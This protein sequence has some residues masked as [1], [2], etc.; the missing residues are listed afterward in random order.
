M[1]ILYGVMGYGR[2]HATRTAAVLPALAADHE[3]K[4]V[5]GVDAYEY[6]NPLF[7]DVEQIPTIGYAYGSEGRISVANTL[8]RNARPMTDL[9]LAKGAGSRRLDEI[10]R[11][12]QPD[13]IISDSE[14][15]THRAAKRWGIPRISF[16]HVGIMAY[17]RP[18]LPAADWWLGHRDALG[19]RLLMGWPDRVLVSSFYPALPHDPRVEVIGPLLRDAVYKAKAS[20]GDYL[21]AYFNKGQHQYSDRLEVE[22]RKLSMPVRVYGTGREG[23]VG[24]LEY[25][26][27]SI[28]GFIADLAGAQAVLATAGHQLISE[29]LYFAKPLYLLPEDCFEQRLNAYMVQRMGVGVRGD[30]VSLNAD[31]LEDF[32]ANVAGYAQRAG[33]CRNDGRE[34][35]LATLQRFLTELSPAAIAV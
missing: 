8:L 13:V 28:D 7:E 25:R 32:L 29:A 33:A 22:L 11:S 14:G 17:C 20:Q 2:G 18:P 23:S 1:K 10:I 15:W 3:I 35:A 34:Q 30:L 5:G 6:L 9:L 31:R 21:M 12:W 16:D 26:P 27:P 19:Y 24:Q 4:V